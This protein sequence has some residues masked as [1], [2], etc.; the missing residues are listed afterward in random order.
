VT[1]VEKEV[2]LL[3][4]I[5]DMFEIIRFAEFVRFDSFQSVVTS[6]NKLFFFRHG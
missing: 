1:F 6:L 5:F 3:T 2:L 4:T